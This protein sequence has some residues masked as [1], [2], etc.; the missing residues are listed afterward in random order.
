MKLSQLSSFA[1]ACLA[2]LLLAGI[3]QACPTCKDQLA[4]DPETY[5]IARGYFWSILF[6]LTMPILIFT[7]LGS[8]FYWEVR[9]AYAKEALEQMQS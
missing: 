4:S 9:R 2:V 1:L 8:Y 3:A 6:M 7:G 5:N